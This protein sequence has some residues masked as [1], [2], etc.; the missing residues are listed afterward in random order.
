[1]KLLL[2]PDDTETLELILNSSKDETKVI[3]VNK[4][5]TLE[6]F[7]GKIQELNLNEIDNI[8]LCFDNLG[9]RAPFFQFTPEELSVENEKIEEIIDEEEENSGIHSI[10]L[11]KPKISSFINKGEFFSQGLKDVLYY[12]KSQSP[13]LSILDIL[14]NGVLLV[15]S[16]ENFEIRTDDNLYIYFDSEI[17]AKTLSIGFKG[18]RAVPVDGNLSTPEDLLALMQSTDIYDMTRSYNLMND[19]DMS[20]YESESI[21]NN[22]VLFN[23]NFNGNGYSIKINETKANAWYGLFGYIEACEV[24]NLNIVY[25]NNGFDITFNTDPGDWIMM[26][27]IAGY[28]SSVSYTNCNVKYTQDTTLSST[29]TFTTNRNVMIGG[30][31]GYVVESPLN[32]CNTIFEKTINININSNF[33]IYNALFVSYLFKCLINNC[34]LIS[35]GD[36]SLEIISLQ[37]ASDTYFLATGVISFSS[38]SSIENLNINLKNFSINATAQRSNFLIGA[39]IGFLGSGIIDPPAPL[40]SISN[41]SLQCEDFAAN[42]IRP[43]SENTG[44]NNIS[45]VFG[46]I[47]NYR[48]GVNNCSFIF[49]NI[50]LN[51]NQEESSLLSSTRFAGL[52]GAIFKNSS[53]NLLFEHCSL[54][55]NKNFDINATL[56]YNNSLSGIVINIGAL[57]GFC[58]NSSNFV[59]FPSY[60]LGFIN[61]Y[62]LNVN[63]H[64]SIVA[65]GNIQIN[66]GGIAGR[67]FSNASGETYFDT[68]YVFFGESSVQNIPS[69]PVSFAGG[70]I[71]ILG[72]GTPAN[73]NNA[74]YCACIYNNYKII[75]QNFN[76]TI[77]FN[78]GTTNNILSISY[79]APIDSNGVQDIDGPSTTQDIINL[80]NNPDTNWLAFLLKFRQSLDS[81]ITSAEYL[82]EVLILN[83]SIYSKTTLNAAFQSSMYFNGLTNFEIPFSTIKD[84]LIDYPDLSED[85]LL[86][87][88]IPIDSVYTLNNNKLYY[89]FQNLA[90]IK[91]K[92]LTVPYSIQY[93]PQS[94]VLTDDNTE[95]VI[96]LGE[97]NTLSNGS[98]IKF[99]GIGSGLVEITQETPPTPPTPSGSNTNNW[100]WITILIV[101]AI[102]LCVIIF[103]IFFCGKSPKIDFISLNI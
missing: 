99:S 37:N 74:S 92:D 8:A 52:C 3:I 39:F 91:N 29:Y 24:S 95:K 62:N 80:F 89:L 94:I 38:G 21:G 70:V 83:P 19:I 46:Q 98:K 10:K 42:C 13:S 88:L 63:I 97:E 18:P 76:K 102:I 25:L 100:W 90:S 17:N 55:V 66:S 53:N 75:G 48:G 72:S 32:N 87:Y 36:A 15:E 5:E 59:F 57:F 31:F 103:L 77:A 47:N 82:T 67:V 71:G 16:I 56:N 84:S 73:R 81:S 34:N 79:G 4:F 65:P 40:P 26:G 2:I 85:T 33:E 61:N 54:I 93:E 49:N 68:T 6:S 64:P 69:G 101:F 27:G 28:S 35:K 44:I 96:L 1:M 45:G 30:A 7:Q 58:Q 22:N 43:S 9:N 11:Y 14:S 20:G 23:G 60:N 86:E 50:D 12:L 78:G 41:C 51:F